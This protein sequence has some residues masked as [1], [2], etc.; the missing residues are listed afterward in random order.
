VSS[1]NR[2]VTS[3]SAIEAV[4]IRYVALSPPLWKI[5]QLF[6]VVLMTAALAACA[7]APVTTS[8]SELSAARQQTTLLPTKKRNQVAFGTRMRSPGDALVAPDSAVGFASFYTEGSRTASGER[9][10]PAELTAAHPSCR[11]AREYVLQGSIRG[12]P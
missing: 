7:Q 4:P 10:N 11:L 9:L 5:A 3:R 6:E 8:R 2:P 1:N 12:N